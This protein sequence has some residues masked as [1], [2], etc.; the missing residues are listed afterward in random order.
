[1]MQVAHLEGSGLRGMYR[2]VCMCSMC[3]YI[4]VYIYIYIY[5]GQICLCLYLWTCSKPCKKKLSAVIGP[6]LAK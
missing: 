6:P 5:F 3:L 2:K 4:Y 1:M